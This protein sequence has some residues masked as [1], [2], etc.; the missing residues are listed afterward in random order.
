[1]ALTD[2]LTNIAD[3]I[4]GKTGKT[5]ELTLDQMA[6]E[7]AGIETGG[8]GGIGAVK[9][10]DVDITVEASTTTAVT[11]TVDGLEFMTSIENPTKW[12]SFSNDDVY[13]AFI[14]PKEITGTPT[15]TTNIYNCSMCTGAGNSNYASLSNQMSYGTGNGISTQAYGI[16]NLTLNCTNIVNGKPTGNLT[17]SVR[18]HSSNG[19]EVVAG[20]YNIQVWYL[21]SFDWGHTK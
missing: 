13:I 8:G 11:Y 16:Y 7:I 3:A 9:F 1:M 19:Y 15:T 6:T 14:T 5:E 2:K 12:T 20:T 18:S 21:T 10:I 4:R 17:V